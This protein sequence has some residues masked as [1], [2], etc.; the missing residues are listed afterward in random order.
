MMR[1]V[2]IV[3]RQNWRHSFSSRVLIASAD[4]INIK[5]GFILYGSVLLNEY[6]LIF[7]WC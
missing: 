2:P 7:V 4:F 1:L 5:S 3:L 6:A